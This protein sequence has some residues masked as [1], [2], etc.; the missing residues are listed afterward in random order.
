MK[1]QQKTVTRTLATM[2]C[3]LAAMLTMACAF[4]PSTAVARDDSAAEDLGWQLG[5]QAYSFNR[6]TF[7]EAVDKAQSVEMKYIEA[8]P[9]QKVS[10]DLDKQMGPG[11]TADERKIVKAKLKK[12][13]ITLKNFGVTGANGEDGWKNLFEFAKD[14]GIETI[15]AEPGE[16][17]FDI[18]EKMCD[19]YEINLAIHNHPNPSHYWNPDTVLKVT[20]GRSKRIGACADTGHW[21]RSGLNP[22]E[23]LKK[24]EGRII[25]LHFKDLHEKGKSGHDVPWGTGVNDVYNMLAELKRQNFKGVFSIEYEH[26]WTTSLPEIAKCVRT[27]DAIAAALQPKGFQPLFMKDLSNASM[28]KNG[29]SFKNGVLKAEGK[30]DIWTKEDY[31]NFVIDLEFQCADDTNSGVFLRTGDIV[32]WLHT[33]IE[34]QIQQQDIDTNRHNMGGLFDVIGPSKSLIKPAGKWNHYTII[35][36]DNTI[37]SVLN[38]ETVM[39]ADLDNWTEAHKNPDGSANKFNTAY[40]DMPKTGKIGLQ[41]H[42]H[43]VAF[44]NM[45]VKTLGM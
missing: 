23:C 31:A 14:M 9:G 26:N 8:Y 5:P 25:S 11:L 29:W 33:G 10:A 17:Q 39:G 20:E 22:L 24:L 40:K 32:N 1:Q 35:A 34:V 41:Y 42:G 28:Q 13:G 2:I 21:Q 15:V 44:R 18:I 19:K 38:G 6:Y 45:T 30:G 12:A 16:D 4:T 3:A 7:F 36:Q 27:F 37:I 43:P